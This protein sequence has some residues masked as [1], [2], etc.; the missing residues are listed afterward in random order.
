MKPILERL[1]KG[2]IV[3]ADGAMG[4]ML[5][6]KGLE[7]GDC[8]ERFNLTKPDIVGSISRLYV[9]AGAEIIQTNTFGASPAKLASY[10]L[11]D[12]TEE[13]NRKAVVIARNA[14]KK[15]VTKVMET[16]AKTGLEKHAYISGSCGSTGK[17]LKP[18]G[19]AD[20]EELYDGFL[21]QIKILVDEGADIIC[22]ETMT[23]LQEA[24]LALKA[25]KSLSPEIPVIATMTFDETP[26]GFYTIMGFGI[27]EAAAGLEDAGADIIGSNC[28]N[29]MEKMIRIAREFKKHSSLPL[30]IQSNAG[31]PE[32]RNGKILYSESPGY[33]A[34]K[35]KDLIEVGVSIIGGCCGTTPEHIRSIRNTVDIS[36]SH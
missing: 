35:A 12:R 19:E 28:G 34:E 10:S 31:L 21:K 22:V 26:K 5:F 32:T 13:I 23:D 4:T 11:E 25:A 30:I 18:H 8:P 24:A 2:E 20:P 29:G 33:F 14:A 9:K 36:K 3:V 6:E 27:K 1:K 16:D 7:S 15:S 17:I